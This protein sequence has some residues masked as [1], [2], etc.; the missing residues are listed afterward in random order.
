MSLRISRTDAYDHRTY[1]FAC[2]GMSLANSFDVKDPQ[3]FLR[4]LTNVLNE[5]DQSKE[6]GDRPKMVTDPDVLSIPLLTA[7]VS[8]L[9]SD[10]DDRSS[11]KTDLQTM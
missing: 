5:Y 8:V 9:C 3:D 6:E 11:A 4:G 10:R 7:V 1:R 2:L